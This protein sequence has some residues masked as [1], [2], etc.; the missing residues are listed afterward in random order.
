MAAMWSVANDLISIKLVTAPPIIE[1]VVSR[2]YTLPIPC[3]SSLRPEAYILQPSEN[4]KPINA[5]IGAVVSPVKGVK[6]VIR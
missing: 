1:P 6:I 4:I 5:H 3:A 2:I